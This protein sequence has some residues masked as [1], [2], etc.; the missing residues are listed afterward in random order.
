M[1]HGFKQGDV[2]GVI[3]SAIED[4]EEWQRDDVMIGLVNFDWPD[5]H[6]AL[7]RMKQEGERKRA[8]LNR[9]MEKRELMCEA[10][11]HLDVDVSKLLGLFHYLDN[12]LWSAADQQWP[13]TKVHLQQV[14]LRLSADPAHPQAPSTGKADS[15]KRRRGRVKN[16]E[17]RSVIQAMIDS[18]DVERYAR[19]WKQ[20]LAQYQDR[21]PKKWKPDS[22]RKAVER[23]EARRGGQK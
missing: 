6:P 12:E 8:A 18:G 2:I 5:H 10:L 21:L 7:V 20:L 17:L 16:E 9:F 1:S 22:L 19:K 4:F 15:K 3:T 11:I 13:E 14:A 23:E